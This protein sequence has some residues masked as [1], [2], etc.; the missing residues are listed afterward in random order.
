MTKRDYYE[1]LQVN[2]GA[3]EAEIKKAYRKA[4]M[5]YHPDKFTSATEKEK[6]EAEDKF[7][8]ANEAYQVLSDPEKRQKY[9]QFGHAAFEQ[10]GGFS[11]GAGFDFGDIF[12]DIFGSG[13]GGGF[14][15]FGGF[16]G[17]SGRSY[18]EA[19]ADLRYTLEITLEEA[20]QGVEKKIKYKRT[21]KCNTCDGTGAEDKHLKT[22]ARCNGSGHIITQQRTILGVM[23]SQTVCPDCHGR[24]EVPEKKC[25]SCHGSGVERETLE[26]KIN[27]PAGIDDG[28]KLKLS[29]FG[30]ASTSGGP[31]GDLYVLIKI[32]R[33]EIFERDE[34]DLYCEIPIS[35]S[36]AVLGGEIEIPTLTAKKTIKIPEGIES[37]KSLRVRGEGIK[38]LRSGYKGDIIV[39]II[40][41]TPRNLSDKQKDLLHKFEESLNEKNYEKKTSFFKKVKKF[42]KDARDFVEKEMEK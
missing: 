5:K 37:G 28:Q 29:G 35:Y 19:G 3:S 24:G 25:K 18:V 34:D 26:R 40:I 42:F 30:D 23:Q 31:N 4:A 9:D 14:S 21:G 27:I 2:K 17:S 16:G 41:E 15:G 36:M 11:G 20:A 7:K 33:H 1:V 22:C 13:F 32:K 38:S 10:G 39:K 8:E 6:K 12:G